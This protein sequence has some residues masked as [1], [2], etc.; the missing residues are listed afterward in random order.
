MKVSS[1][2]HTPLRNKPYFLTAPRNCSW[3]HT[4]LRNNQAF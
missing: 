2:R 4:P 3:R 1:W